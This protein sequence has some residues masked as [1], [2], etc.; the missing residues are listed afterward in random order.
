LLNNILNSFYKCTLIVSRIT[1][2]DIY[3][4]FLIFDAIF[5][6][7]NYLKK[8]IIDYDCSL[9]EIIIKACKKT[10]TKLVK[11]YLK[12]KELNKMLYNLVNILNSTQKLSFYKM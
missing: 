2:I 10:S 3:F 1:N 12:I 8:T 4:E 9:R 11:Y 7:L 5:N 6:Y